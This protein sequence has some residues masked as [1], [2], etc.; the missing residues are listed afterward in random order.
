MDQYPNNSDNYR[1]MKHA[2]VQTQKKVERVANG[3]VQRK[4]RSSLKELT[5][6]F[7]QEE[8]ATVRS[9]LWNDVL[10]PAAKKTI[11]DMI[12][13]GLEMFFYGGTGVPKRN[14]MDRASW[15]DGWHDSGTKSVERVKSDYG[16]SFDDVIFQNRG[17]AERVLEVLFEIID[18]YKAVSVADLYSAAGVTGNY[19]DQNYGWEDIRGAKIVRF[20]D[21]YLLKMPKPMPLN[22]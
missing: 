6:G 2:D 15:R 22:R 4:K 14:K 20:S 13:S 17:D 3:D 19:T 1:D 7:I 16:Y 11:Y 21:G 8:V 10:I 12:T 9:S 18:Q 5:D